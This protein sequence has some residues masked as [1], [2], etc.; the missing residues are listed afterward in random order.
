MALTANA[1]SQDRPAKKWARLALLGAA[2]VCA[3]INERGA[4]VP[5]LFMV[6]YAFLY[7]KK[8]GID[9]YFKLALGAALLFYGLFIIRIV[10][11]SQ[12][13]YGGFL[14]T[15]WHQLVAVTHLPAFLPMVELFLLV[16]VPLLC[17]ALFEWRAAVI[18]SVLML[19]NIFGNIGGAEK[20]GW[21]THYPSFYFTPLVWA[22]LTGYAALYSKFNKRNQRAATL[23]GI[24]VFIA[25]LA[26]LN[27]S[28]YQSINVSAAN[29]QQS[30]WPAFSD[31]ARAFL[32]QGSNRMAFAQDVAGLQHAVP[33]GSVVSTVEAGMPILY[34][35]RT[36]QFFPEDI[37]H[38]DY[39]VLGA[40]I[41][42]GKTVY[43]GAVNYNTPQERQ[44]VDDLVLARLKHDGYD[45]AHP[46][47][48]P[49]LDGLAVVRRVH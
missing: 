26:M 39:A 38:A 19:P 48:F 32:F 1:V 15:N 33:P 36:I 20:L 41:V 28:S 6:M 16:N 34:E 45:L 4:I 49:G 21:P 11:P 46:V 7:W 30:F 31:Q 18:A 47:L 5:G 10:L 43:G 9:R 29:V 13:D 37:D 40:S 23:A 17:L 3:S 22:A 25:F 24:A 8:P 44:E 35:G 12:G 42:D 27:P 2:V 14:P